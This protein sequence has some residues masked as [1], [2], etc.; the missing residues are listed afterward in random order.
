MEWKDS[1]S[2]NKDVLCSAEFTSRYPET[3]EK[4]FAELMENEMAGIWVID[5]SIKSRKVTIDN[6]VRVSKKFY[7]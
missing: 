7:R 6:I 2:D 5:P 1:Q 3:N 4:V